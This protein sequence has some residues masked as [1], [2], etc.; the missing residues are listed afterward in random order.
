MDAL[1]NGKTGRQTLAAMLAALDKIEPAKPAPM[2]S[3]PV[4]AKFDAASDQTP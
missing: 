3:L 2:P 4:N 1:G